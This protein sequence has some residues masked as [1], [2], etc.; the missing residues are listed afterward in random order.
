MFTMLGLY[1][2]H[3]LRKSVFFPYILLVDSAYLLIFLSKYS[4]SHIASS[5]KE[6]RNLPPPAGIV[7]TH[8][9]TTKFLLTNSYERTTTTSYLIDGIGIR[10]SHASPL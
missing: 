5:W 6:N 4:T 7:P 9:K 10:F 8:R 1:A 3:S 2:Y